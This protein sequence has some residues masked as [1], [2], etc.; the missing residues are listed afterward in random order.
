[1]LKTEL[2]TPAAGTPG[3]HL[4]SVGNILASVGSLQ[5]PWCWSGRPGRRNGRSLILGR[6]LSTLSWTQ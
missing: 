6:S 4:T 2:A 1:V 3:F 5:P